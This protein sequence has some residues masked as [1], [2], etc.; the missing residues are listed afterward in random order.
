[1]DEHVYTRRE[2]NRTKSPT[3]EQ[4]TST[5]SGKPV[6]QVVIMVSNLSLRPLENKV[7]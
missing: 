3:Q 4:T 1:M 2:H 6:R 5:P 7:R